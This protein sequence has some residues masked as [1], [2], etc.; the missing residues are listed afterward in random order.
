MPDLPG[1]SYRDGEYIVHQGEAGE[2]MYFVQS[3]EVEVVRRSGGREFYLAVLGA[4]EFFGEMALL[5]RD[6]RSA[7]VR[8]LGDAQVLTLDKNSFLL[9]V[10]QDPSLAFR[11]LDRMSNRMR[12]LTD[13]LRNM[14]GL[15]PDEVERVRTLGDAYPLGLDKDSFLGQ[16]RQNPQFAF[17]LL[18]DLSG[19]I[20]EMDD[21]L[22]NMSS[23]RLDEV[24]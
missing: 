8:A 13:R 16:V 1:K 20:R 2:C 15:L 19:R 3:G 14:G 18:E 5:E 4:G 9:Q 23:L 7:S 22:V 17:R 12:E 11:M 10:Q 24:R 6:V 21:R